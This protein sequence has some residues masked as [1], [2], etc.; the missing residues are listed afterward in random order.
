MSQ[1]QSQKSP[2]QRI[3]ITLSQSE[4]NDCKAVAKLRQSNKEEFA[5]ETRKFVQRL[6]DQDLHDIGVQ[7][8]F[9]VAKYLGIDIDRSISPS[10]D[11]KVKDLQY[12]DAKIQVRARFKRANGDLFFN[13]LEDFKANVAV[14]V[15][16][17]EDGNMEIVGWCSK[18]R[19]LKNHHIDNF[20]HG[21]RYCLLQEHLRDMRDLKAALIEKFGVISS[22][23]LTS[24]CSEFSLGP[25]QEP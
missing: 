2:I 12:G 19:F 23:P 14:L 21:Q 9:G 13:N 7:T 11:D 16:F 6:S 18:D 22:N 4:I 5:V 24:V 20:G 15:I 1:D 8:E 17:Y 3:K 25:A 10:G